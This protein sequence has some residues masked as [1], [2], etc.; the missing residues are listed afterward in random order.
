MATMDLPYAALL[1]AMLVLTSFVLGASVMW[2]LESKRPR[3][4]P[5]WLTVA[6]HLMMIGWAATVFF[7]RGLPSG[8]Y[9]ID[10]RWMALLGVFAV[11]ASVLAFFLEIRY[12]RTHAVPSRS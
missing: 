4:Q 12:R 6:R 9:F 1:V 11:A 3:R 5:M 10:Q 7:G 8:F 2:S